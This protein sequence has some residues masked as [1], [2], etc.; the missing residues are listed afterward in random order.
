MSDMEGSELATGRVRV[1][2]AT[3]PDWLNDEVGASKRGSE[4]VSNLNFET[5]KSA[6]PCF[7]TSFSPTLAGGDNRGEALR[8]LFQQENYA[9]K[10]WQ[11]HHS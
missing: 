7:R 9:K 2:A 1:A 10:I 6:D 3:E 5:L 4:R 11:R 8:R